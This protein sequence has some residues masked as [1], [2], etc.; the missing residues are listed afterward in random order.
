MVK[1]YDKYVKFIVL[2]YVGYFSKKVIRVGNILFIFLLMEFG[3]MYFIL[4]G[5]FKYDVYICKL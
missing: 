2:F 3:E 4:Y 1:L 5:C